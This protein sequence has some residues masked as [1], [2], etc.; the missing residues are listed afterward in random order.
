MNIYVFYEIIFIYYTG[1]TCC[2]E[3]GQADGQPGLSAGREIYS[4]ALIFGNDGL[5][6]D[7]KRIAGAGRVPRTGNN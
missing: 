5:K 7:G 6:T 3:A 4:A 1:H 2:T